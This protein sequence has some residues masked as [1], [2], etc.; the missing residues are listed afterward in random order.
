MRVCVCVCVCVN[1]F[2]CIYIS[3]YLI[4]SEVKCSLDINWYLYLIPRCTI[5]S[6]KTNLFRGV[7]VNI[8]SPDVLYTLFIVSVHL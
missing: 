8:K 6:L 2:M 7:F 4:K 5:I 1:L 3:I